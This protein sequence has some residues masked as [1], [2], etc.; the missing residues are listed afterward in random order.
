MEGQ[1]AKPTDKLH[2]GEKKTKQPTTY[3]KRK[4]PRAYLQIQRTTARSTQ[5]GIY[6]ASPR[7]EHTS[8]SHALHAPF[9][10]LQGSNTTAMRIVYDA[11]AKISSKALSLNDCLHTGPNL[12]QR[13]QNMLL[14]FR[15]HKIAFTADIEKAFLQIELNTQDRD[16]TRFLWL[17]DVDKSANNPDNLAVYRFCRVLFGAAQSPYLL[18]ATIQ[19][20]LTKQDDWISE[21]LQRS[22]YMDNVV[23]GTDTEPEALQ[24]YT[25]SR[26]CFQKA[27]MNLRQWTSNSPAL[28]RQAHDDGVYAE[29]MVKDRYSVTFISKTDQAN[30][31]HRKSLQKTSIKLILKT[32]RPLGIC[33][34][35]DSKSEN[36]DAGTMETQLKMGP[37]TS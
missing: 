16:A 2:I 5:E 29:P 25:S 11:S 22:I 10:S 6:R 9:S 35:S 8:R 30:R 17:K 31:Q 24:Y 20:H 32:L 18:N 19:H 7:P 1:Q 23:T 14:A 27:G 26:N 4:T 28:N 21:D 3:P 13:L 34:T 37:R 36:N 33:G 12:I 15:S